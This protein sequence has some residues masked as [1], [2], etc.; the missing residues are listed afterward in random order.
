MI[1]LRIPTGLFFSATGLI[2]VGL[3][4]IFPETR[5]LLTTANVNLYTGLVMLLFG[6]V[7]LVLA[8]RSR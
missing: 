2:L 4:V 5:S 1:D 3:G 7:M 6:G 8:R